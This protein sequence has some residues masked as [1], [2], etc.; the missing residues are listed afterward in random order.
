MLGVG[1]GCADSSA[2]AR[3]VPCTTH[4]SPAPAH[5]LTHTRLLPDTHSEFVVNIMSEWFVEAANHTCGDYPRGVDEMKLA[6]LTPLASTKVRGGGV[7]GGVCGGVGVWEAW[8][9]R[10]GCVGVEL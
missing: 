2:C 5:I 8:G 4:S 6:G 9:S 3:C 7:C 1:A 10:G